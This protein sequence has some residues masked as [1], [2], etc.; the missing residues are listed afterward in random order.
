MRNLHQMCPCR[1]ITTRLTKLHSYTDHS[2]SLMH[3][4][5]ECNDGQ[6]KWNVLDINHLL[7]PVSRDILQSVPSNSLPGI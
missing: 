3:L 7:T 1:L 4:G 5:K 6:F 2:L